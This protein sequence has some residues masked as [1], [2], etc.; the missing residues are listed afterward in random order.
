MSI[1]LSYVIHI[2]EVCATCIMSLNTQQLALVSVCARLTGHT[3]V[4]MLLGVQ[5]VVSCCCAGLK[6]L[7]HICWNSQRSDVAASSIAWD[8]NAVSWFVMLQHVI[9]DFVM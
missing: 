1:P 7:N 9:D 6:L 4:S 8:M 5:G 3:A 2:S